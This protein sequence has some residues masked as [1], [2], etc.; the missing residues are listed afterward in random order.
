MPRTRVYIGAECTMTEQCGLIAADHGGEFCKPKPRFTSEDRRVYYRNEP[1]HHR[2][3]VG[4]DSRFKLGRQCELIDEGDKEPD[5][6]VLWPFLDTS[7][8]RIEIT[9]NAIKSPAVFVNKR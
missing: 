8:E 3:G 9:K 7:V 5:E 2:N 1:S 6:R 4:A